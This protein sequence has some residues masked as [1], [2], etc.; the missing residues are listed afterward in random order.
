MSQVNPE[1][2]PNNSALFCLLRDT[3]L[4]SCDLVAYG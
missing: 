1:P 3:G 2:L 4:Q